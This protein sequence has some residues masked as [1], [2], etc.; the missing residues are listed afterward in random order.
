VSK[1]SK[2][3]EWISLAET[4]KQL[5][6]L[7]ECELQEADVL[8][9]A[10]DGHLKVSV[11]FLNGVRAR[12]CEVVAQENTQWAI[13]RVN[14]GNGNFVLAVDDPDNI[15]D[16]S[17]VIDRLGS[18]VTG[19]PPHALNLLRNI[20]VNEW[21]NYSLYSRDDD[22]GGGRYLRITDS[23]ETLRGIYDLPMIGAEKLAVERAFQSHT[24]GHAITDIILAGCFVESC[25]GKIYQLLEAAENYDLESIEEAIEIHSHVLSSKEISLPD[26]ANAKKRHDEL[27]KKLGRDKRSYPRNH[28]PADS[29]LVIRTK[30]LSDFEQAINGNSGTVEKPLSERE[31]TTLLNIIGGLL[32]LMLSKSPGGKPQSVF[33]NQTAI[34]DGLLAHFEGKPGISVRTL[35]EKFAIAKRNLGTI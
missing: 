20:P 11:R 6:P 16:S 26:L 34:I 35:E 19:F 14:G 27:M 12:R 18:Q 21:S 29:T 7:L 28:L 9:F 5:S 4:A 30:L 25:D 8:R 15:P 22:I 33:N 23:E 17:E 10:I 24:D 32:E 13:E 3:K 31:R 1:F 2:L